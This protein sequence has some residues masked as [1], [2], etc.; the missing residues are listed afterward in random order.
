MG[1]SNEIPLYN[2]CENE[3]CWCCSSSSR[4]S[5]GLRFYSS[6]LQS[7]TLRTM[8]RRL[9]DVSEHHKSLVAIATAEQQV[10][11]GPPPGISS[12]SHHQNMEGYVVLVWMNVVDN[13]G[14]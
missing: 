7:G 11:A 4:Y 10:G 3:F 12:I 13:R 9:L 6:L 2:I 5:Q 1:Q 14:Y 8:K